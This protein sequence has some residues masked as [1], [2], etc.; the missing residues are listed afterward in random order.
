[1]SSRLGRITSSA[2]GSPPW[3]ATRDATNSA[4]RSVRCLAW[5]AVG[6]PPPHDGH[7]GLGAAELVDA[8]DVD[9]SSAQDDARAVAE[10]G[11]LVEVVRGE[12]DR[13]ALGLQAADELPELAA[14]LGVEPGGGLVEEEQLGA[15]DDAEGHV[16]PSPLAARELRHPGP[17]LRLEADRRDHLVDVAR[18]GKE[19]GEVGQ[20]LA[21]GV[22]ARLRR[23]LQHD[24]EPGLPVEVAVRGIDAEHADLAR[25]AQ[26]VAL[27]DLDGRRLAGAVRAEQGEGLTAGDVEVDAVDGDDAAVRLAQSADPH[28]GIR[29][30]GKP[31]GG[32]ARVGRC[33]VHAPEPAGSRRPPAAPVRSIPPSTDRW[34]RNAAA[35]PGRPRPAARGVPSHSTFHRRSSLTTQPEP[36]VAC[37]R[38]RRRHPARPSPASVQ[39]GKP[40]RSV[41]PKR[42]GALVTTDVRRKATNVIA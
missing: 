13:R 36:W 33:H 15:A 18:V 32:R 42:P 6:V 12:Q 1:M 20:L 37:S 19:P 40:A 10:L 23:R 9:Q 7:A 17:R 4:G 29:A 8:P 26:A 30:G 5:R 2:S 31:A 28:R 25:R 38:L 24:A 16:D 14:G 11:R 35:V 27:E 22:V 34:M 39:P 3:R 21:H 41:S